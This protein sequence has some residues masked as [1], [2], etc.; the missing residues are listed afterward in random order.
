MQDFLETSS[1]DSP[2]SRD[3][4][5]HHSDYQQHY[6]YGSRSAHSGYS[7]GQHRQLDLPT[8]G[9]YNNHTY[10]APRGAIGSSSLVTP[11]EPCDLVNGDNLGHHESTPLVAAGTVNGLY[12]SPS[13]VT[14]THRPS[15]SNGGQVINRTYTSLR[16]AAAAASSAR[17]R[18]P[19]ETDADGSES[20]ASDEDS[21]FNRDE[22]RARALNIP[23]ATSDIINLPIDEFNERLAK[24]D[25]SEAQLSLIRDIRRR[26]KNKVA[27]QNCRKRKMD[28][29]LGLQGEVDRLFAQKESLELQQAHLLSLRDL[30]RDKYAKLYH[31]ILESKQTLTNGHF[32]TTLLTNENPPDD[33]HPNRSLIVTSH[34]SHP[35][36]NSSISTSINGTSAPLIATAAGSSSSSSSNSH[37]NIKMELLD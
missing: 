25:L 33:P 30:A 37:G 23:I 8:V 24:Y 10:S 15:T 12:S 26:G 18:L 11:N 5:G 34:L 21:Q 2:H 1:V 31:F 29:I 4:N 19:S 7:N 22:R 6:Y 13:S 17:S 27:A 28:Q 14:G 35:H 3:Y 9:L 32:T 16:A 20:I 36:I